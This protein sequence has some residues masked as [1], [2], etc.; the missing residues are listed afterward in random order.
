[1]SDYICF[2][3]L[4]RIILYLGLKQTTRLALVCSSWDLDFVW[5]AIRSLKLVSITNHNRIER[6]SGPFDFHDASTLRCLVKFASKFA[7][8]RCVTIHCFPSMLSFQESN[9]MQALYGQ[10]VR[11]FGPR[12]FELRLRGVRCYKSRYD[13][14]ESLDLQ[15]IKVLDAEDVPFQALSALKNW[16]QNHGST[17]KELSVCDSTYPY[18]TSP[19][20]L[21]QWIASA[22]GHLEKLTVRV[23]WAKQSL[24]EGCKGL[25]VIAA[26]NP[27]L[28][29]VHIRSDGAFS[30]R[31]DA[32]V[33]IFGYMIR[34]PRRW[35]DMETLCIEK[36]G[37]SLK[38]LRFDGK[39]A[40]E[41]CIR[42]ASMEQVFIH[43]GKNS[44]LLRSC[45]K[46]DDVAGMRHVLNQFIIQAS[47]WDADALGVIQWARDELDSLKQ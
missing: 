10:F 43:S 13:I 16:K 37:I 19:E 33:A 2:D 28:Q 34:E 3:V 36:T 44:F 38:Q 47:R 32:F 39:T 30:H 9:E 15:R 12:L 42:T 40:W 21:C 8:I 5:G 14:F 22:S 17:L 20:R 26:T 29:E 7:S 27:H 41:R 35:D 1:M 25:Q 46:I 31:R 11:A 45:F 4:E 23:T 6:D 24:L 18:Q